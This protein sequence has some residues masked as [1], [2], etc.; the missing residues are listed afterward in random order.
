HQSAELSRALREAGAEPIECPL[1]AICDP[2]KSGPLERAVQELG[3][4][5]WVVFT[6]ANGV[7]R[8]FGEL[9]RVHKDARQ[10]GNA[11]IAAIGPKTAAAL[12]E[13]SI[14]ADVVPEEYR[15]EAVA[16]AVLAQG[17]IAGRRVLLARAAV[18]REI[19]PQTLRAAGAQVDVVAAY[20][21]ESLSTQ[22]MYRLRNYL[23]EGTIDIATFTSSSTVSSMI[24]ALGADVVS[25]LEPSCVA[26]IGPITAETA[27]NSGIRV[28][29]VASDYT[30]EGLVDALRDHYTSA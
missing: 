1:I 19:L 6:S 27:R 23:E 22:H 2:V 18:A 30:V 5:A 28:D 29:V 24:H 13:Y 3:T 7:H 10:F 26:A 15:G 4:Y 17:P 20:R 11:R 9:S 25:L 21:T 16:A 12:Q 8:L 14:R